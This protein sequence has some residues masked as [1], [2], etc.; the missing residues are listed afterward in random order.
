MKGF[1]LISLSLQVTANMYYVVYQVIQGY[2]LTIR[3]W[4]RLGFGLGL[5]LC[6]G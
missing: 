5:W 6:K 3:L 4:V 2:G 1:H